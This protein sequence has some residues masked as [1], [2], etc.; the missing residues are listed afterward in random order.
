MSENAQPK[1]RP[2]YE[3]FKVNGEKP[4]SEWT[5]VGAVWENLRGAALIIPEGIAVSGRIVLLPPP[6]AP[7]PDGPDI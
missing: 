4:H 2:L 6:E 7:M 5:K 3:A 1:R